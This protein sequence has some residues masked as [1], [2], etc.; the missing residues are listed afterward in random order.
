MKP[1]DLR[2]GMYVDLNC[3]WFKHPFPKKN[4]KLTHA[5]QIQTI[6]TLGLTTI[7][8]NRSLSD[9]QVFEVDGTQTG[10]SVSA[11]TAVESIPPP[12]PIN[13]LVMRDTGNTSAAVPHVTQYKDS[14]QQTEAA[15]QKVLGQSQAVL[16]SVYAGSEEGLATAK[17]MLNSLS[18]L[19][20]NDATAGAMA[21]LVNSQDLNDTSTLHA[22]N[23]C[24]LSMMVG[25]QFDLP[26]EELKVL[27]IAALL[28]DIGLQKV[29]GDLLKQPGRLTPNERELIRKH[30]IYGADMVKRF[31]GIPAEAV[32]VILHHHE[33]V[34]GSGYPDALT[35]QQLSLMTKIVMVVEEYDA[36]INNPSPDK[37]LN[38]SEALSHLYVHGK[39]EFSHEVLVAFIQTL[40]VYPPGTVV[41]L[42]DESFGL[43]ISI[44]FK[45]R[46]RPMILLYD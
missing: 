15:Y 14:L 28:H 32:D 17:V 2:V 9:P 29:P 21:I 24:V 4:F 26:A 3:S 36:L 22:L 43:V 34:N 40:S 46:M 41:Q 31:S 20:L 5:R 23:S 11:P 12:V 1:T 30:P 8:V 44:N 13:Q 33:R 19:L 7:L 25:R 27:G 39:N 42:S 16:E 37:N 6:R 45:N 38:P 10:I 35:E 18:D